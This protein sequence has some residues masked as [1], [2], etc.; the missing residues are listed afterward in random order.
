ML[1]I[2]MLFL[3]LE[4]EIRIFTGKPWNIV[5]HCVRMP[6]VKTVQDIT[7][8]FAEHKLFKISVHWPQEDVLGSALDRGLEG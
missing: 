4:R 5:R 1:H 7:G 6:I 3:D 2:I 8:I